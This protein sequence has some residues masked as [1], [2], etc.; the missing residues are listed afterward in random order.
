MKSIF[1]LVDC[2]NFYASC[3]RV[4]DPSLQGKPMIV[5]SNNDGCVVARSNEAK[6]L[7]IGMGVPFF[8]VS[9]LV[10]KHNVAVFS[11]NY[12]LYADMSSRVMQTLANFTPN[13][14]IYSIDEAFLELAGIPKDITEYARKI[15]ATVKKWTGIPV[16]IGIAETK[17]LSKIANHIA[18]RSEKAFGVLNLVDSPY[19]DDALA[20]TDVNDVWGVGCKTAKKLRK[21]SIKTAL[22]LKKANIGYI[23]ENFGVTGCRTVYE[24]RGICCYELEEHPPTRKCVTVSRSFGRDVEDIEHL[25]QAVAAYTAMA[26][27]KLREEKLAASAITVF[28]MTNRFDPKTKYFNSHTTSFATPTANSPELISAAVNAVERIFRKNRKFKKAGVML[29]DLTPEDRIQT[30]LF[31]PV[32]RQKSKQLMKTI[33]FINSRKNNR[34]IWAAQGLSQPW[35]TKFNRRSY[36]YTTRFDELPKVK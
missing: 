20:A 12:A 9:R 28:A 19:V 18:K 13:M 26:A 34:L 5:L 3:E 10:E 2:N 29:L 31:D 4:F 23:R 8:K 36:A 24:L 25:G 30:S 17:T 14:E 35:K 7:G 27:E 15:R 21:T 22:D 11:S 16:S 1:A 6:K 33:D 32:D